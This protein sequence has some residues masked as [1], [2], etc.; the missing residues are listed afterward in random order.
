M[1]I[2]IPYGGEICLLDEVEQPE[3]SNVTTSNKAIIVVGVLRCLDRLEVDS[4]PVMEC[5]SIWVFIWNLLYSISVNFL[6]VNIIYI[7]CVL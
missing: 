4:G 3:T 6:L 2:L 5:K 7:F 1:P